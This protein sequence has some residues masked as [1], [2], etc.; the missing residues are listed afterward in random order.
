M[1]AVCMD[2]RYAHHCNHSSEMDYEP[3]KRSTHK[4]GSGNYAATKVRHE[5]EANT[6]REKGLT[7]IRRD[8]QTLDSFLH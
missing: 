5:N 4:I 1:Q 2:G 3:D 6:E 8:L 7:G